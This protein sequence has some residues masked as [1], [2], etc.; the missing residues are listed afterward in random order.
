[1]SASQQ[2][3]TENNRLTFACVGTARKYFLLIPPGNP[4]SNTVSLIALNPKRVT[5]SKAVI[6]HS[7]CF[8]AQLKTS[9]L[10]PRQHAPS[11]SPP[12]SESGCELR[13]HLADKV[14]PLLR[15][16]ECNHGYYA[17]HRSVNDSCPS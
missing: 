10:S 1:M 16:A 11:A 8:A 4:G 17:A 14:E 7:I 3:P 15:G 2:Q 6:S 9:L 13:A 12:G 5:D